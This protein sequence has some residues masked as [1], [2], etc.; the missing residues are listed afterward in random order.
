[1]R[2][3]S[4]PLPFLVG[5]SLGF[6]PIAVPSLQAP[7]LA[8]NQAQSPAEALITAVRGRDITLGIGTE[9]GAVRGAVYGITRDGRVRAR[10]QIT[11]VAARESSATVLDADDDFVISVGDATRFI[12]VQDLPV[13]PVAPP[14]E[15]PPVVTPTV[16]TPPVVTPTTPDT[17]VVIPVTPSASP[18]TVIVTPP[19]AP[20]TG[21]VVTAV[22]TSSS[23]ATVTSVTGNQVTLEYGILQG[24]RTGAKVPIVR[25]GD[26]IAIVRLDTITDNTST[27]E[28]IWND[29]SVGA[30]TIGDAATLVGSPRSTGTTVVNVNTPNA[31]ANVPA[32]PIL[33]ETGA[34]N[35]VVP[36]AD[37]TYEYLAALAA[38]G[39][40]TSQPAHIFHDEGSRRHRTEEDI[41]FSRSQIAGFIR[42]ALGNAQSTDEMPGTAKAALLALTQDYERE[43]TQQGV[44]QST[45]TSLRQDQGFVFG[46]SGQSRASLVG[47][48]GRGGNVPFSEAGGGLRTR[49]GFDN[50]TSIF[51]Q[52]G[53][54]LRFFAQIDS[55]TDSR[56]GSNDGGFGLSEAYLEYNANRILRGLKVKV[57]RDEVWWGPGH[58]GTLLLSDA[59]GPLNTVQTSFK[60]GSYELQGLYAPLNRGPLGGERSLFGHNFQVRIGSQTRIGFAETLLLP[61]DKFDAI[62]FLSAFSPIPLNFVERLRNRNT[63]PNSGNVLTKAY[64][65]TSLARG[66]RNYAEFLLDDIG[67]NQNNLVRNRLGT[68]IGAHIFTPQDPT[69]L[70]FFAEYAN[71][72]GRT[73]LGLLALNDTD[74]Y[75]RG[76]PLG[77]PVAPPQGQT[78]GGAESVRLEGYWRATP[79][80]RLGAGVEFADLAS[81]QANR[82]RQ[83]VYRL[84]ATYQLSRNFSIVS[85]LQRVATSQPNFV[86]GGVPLKGNM[87]QIEIVQTF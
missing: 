59:A 61:R 36:R 82:S 45:L 70:G 63:A 66:V 57:G 7:V 78:L 24:A 56:Q 64:I 87:Y 13:A 40:I 16:E 49:T 19:V 41:T 33:F 50:R 28:V 18:S 52:S 1:M 29:E 76:R 68:L 8:Q 21:S 44:E 11:E 62:S 37:E 14:V 25:T 77:Y 81:E 12:A 31:N 53:R 73:Y 22:T 67:V 72:Q 34:S 4:R 58:F 17:T 20:P 39:L 6:A 5:I 38:R 74:Y 48:S 86:I 71:L 85:R 23:T 47:G 55:G 32:A 69:K 27:G 79:K 30:V 15:T 2:W 42:E 43:L 83:Q 26:V 46:F 84:R 54:N 10:L 51:G 9:D 3:I 80:L 35:A 75:Y 60:R 65:E